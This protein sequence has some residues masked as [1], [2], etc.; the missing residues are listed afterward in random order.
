MLI[1]SHLPFQSCDDDT[2]RLQLAEIHPMNTVD[3]A[4]PPCHEPV[5]I[6]NID[7]GDL[8]SNIFMKPDFLA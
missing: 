5:G 3:S 1:G 2:R 6:G 7:G 8:R 4:H